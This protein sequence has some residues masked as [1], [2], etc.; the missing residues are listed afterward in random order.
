ANLVFRPEFAH[1]CVEQTLARR[2]PGGETPGYEHRWM[3][4]DAYCH[5]QGTIRFYGRG[6]M[7]DSQAVP[8]TGRGT[9]EHAFGTAPLAGAFRRYVRA[10]VMLKGR[11]T[12]VHLIKPADISAPDRVELVAADSA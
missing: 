6:G 7:V 11:T 8:F 12:F 9:H 5:V 3:L 1:S 2:E 10:K 4:A